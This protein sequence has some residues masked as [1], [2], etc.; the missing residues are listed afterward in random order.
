MIR[1]SC[2]FQINV[3]LFH[4]PL[5]PHCFQ[6]PAFLIIVLGIVTIYFPLHNHNFELKSFAVKA[7]F[8]LSFLRFI[9]EI[10][11]I[12]FF[13]LVYTSNILNC[14]WLLPMKLNILNYLQHLNNIRNHLF[15]TFLFKNIFTPLYIA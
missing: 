3:S 8:K 12:S 11:H 15:Y 7:D 4:F 9:F 1:K 5:F 10:L 2:T 13:F 14:F 6:F